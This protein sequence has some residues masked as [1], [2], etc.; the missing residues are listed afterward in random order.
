[1]KSAFNRLP[2]TCAIA[3]KEWDSIRA[4]LV[5]GR[6]SILLRKGGIDENLGGFRPEHDSF[7]IYPTY[8]HQ[9]TQGVRDESFSARRP[10]VE[11]IVEI[12]SLFP[13]TA[14][15]LVRS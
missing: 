9:S 13:S 4:A 14:R 10:D 15:I 12:D 7:W 2:E 3:F 1:M 6:Q 11:N 5:Q 8:V